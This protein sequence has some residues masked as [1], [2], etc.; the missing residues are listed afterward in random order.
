MMR[1]RTPLSLWGRFLCSG[2]FVTIHADSEAILWAAEEA[3]LIRQ[4]GLE[5]KTDMRWEIVSEQAGGAGLEHECK[6]T[7]D[8]HSLYLNIGPEQW[9][10]FDLETG[11]GAGFVVLSDPDQARDV[12]ALPYLQAVASNVGACLGS[13]HERNW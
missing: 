2:K 1:R 11:D 5:S 7:L 13:E 10:A 9:F 6:V 12:N 3:G 4:K 8:Q